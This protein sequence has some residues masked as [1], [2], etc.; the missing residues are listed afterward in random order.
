M[1]TLHTLHSRTSR[2]HAHFYDISSIVDCMTRVPPYRGF[3]SLN[4]SRCNNRH[5]R[6][7]CYCVPGRHRR[8]SYG[9][10]P[11]NVPRRRFRDTTRTRTRFAFRRFRDVAD[12]PTPIEK[13]DRSDVGSVPEPSS[14]SLR[15]TR[16]SCYHRVRT[17]RSARAFP[18]ESTTG[19]HHGGRWWLS[20]S[21]D[22]M[23]TG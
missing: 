10:P 2:V 6:T 23:I 22:A 3:R 7:R 8:V 12:R 16:S 15:R 20:R 1:G 13:T 4:P 17:T 19:P 14:V 11:S 5:Y 21:S 18:N 9:S